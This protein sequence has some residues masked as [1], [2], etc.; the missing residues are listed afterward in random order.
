MVGTIQQNRRHIPE[1][2]KD[3]RK[4]Q[5]LSSL[6]AFSHPISM[7]SY[8]SNS[9]RNVIL[10]ST[11]HNDNT[12]IA[13]EQLKPEMVH[14]YNNTKAGVDACDQMAR[15]CSTKIGTR[16]WPLACFFNMLDIAAINAQTI[17]M[18]KHK[19]PGT[20]YK[21]YRTK[22]IEILA[23]GLVV[24]HVKQRKLKRLRVRN[25]KITFISKT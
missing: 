10:L 12:I 22:F 7:V 2:S 4:R 1:E 16:R 3:V 13:D 5:L 24:E 20:T 15:H 25:Q 17:W 6:F 23:L 8:K 18:K 14:Y 21:A 11:Q 19:S 9:G